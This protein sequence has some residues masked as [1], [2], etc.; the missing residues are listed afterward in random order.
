M[1]AIEG[2]GGQGVL[3]AASPLAANDLEKGHL[4]RPFGD[5]QTANKITYYLVY[6]KSHMPD[7]L[8]QTFCAWIS[9]NIKQ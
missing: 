7:P 1:A 6:P 2:Q 9:G 5:K 8:V 4:I 3:L